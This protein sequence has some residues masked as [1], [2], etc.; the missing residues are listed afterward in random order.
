MITA[1]RTAIGRHPGLIPVP[2]PVLAMALKAARRGEW[3]QRLT[4][5]LMVDTSALRRLGWTPRIATPAG[6][7]AL[8]ADD[9]AARHAAPLSL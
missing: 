4:G 8:M 6:L 9:G 1:M 5:S 2:A 3:I 7:A